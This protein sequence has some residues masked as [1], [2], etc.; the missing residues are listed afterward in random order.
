MKKIWH[1]F[2]EQWSHH[3]KRLIWSGLAVVVVLLG[4][5]RYAASRAPKTEYT[6]V[7]ATRGALVQSVSETG[8]LQPLS[9]LALNF[10]AAGRVAQT[11]VKVGDQ[12][13]KNQ[14][15]MV[16]DTSGLAI[17]LQQATANLNIAQA[18]L[19][20]LLAGASHEDIAV[21]QANY[22]AAQTA[23]ASAAAQLAQVKTASDAAVAQAQKNVED[24]ADNGFITTYEQAVAQAVVSLDNVAKTYGQAANNQQDSL[25]IT[26]GN[27]LAVVNTA[28]DAIDRII[29]DSSLT[30]Y[31]S[32]RNSAYLRQTQTQY[33][34]AKQVTA[35]AN[36]NLTA[37]AGTPTKEAVKAVYG[38]V[39]AAT[40][41]SLAALNSC[42]KVLE[43]SVAASGGMTQT[44][45]D[46][47]KTNISSQLTAVTAAA[48]I[49]QTAGQTWNDALLAYNTNTA[50]AN[51]ALSQA[52]AALAD[53]RAKTDNGLTNARL[54]RDRDV[55]AAQNQVDSTIKALAV[56]KAQLDKTTAGPRVQDVELQR[57]QVNQA[58][59]S[60]DLLKNQL[61]NNQIMA[62]V[63]G[64][65]TDVA[66]KN[67]EQTNVGQV[68]I[69]MM[70][71]SGFEIE[72]D[73]AETDIAKVKIND[74]A[75]IT[76]DAYGDS[77]KFD[78]QVVFIEPAATVIQGVIYYKVKIDFTAGDHPV[79]PDMTATATIVTARKD[80]V[81]L[82]PLRAVLD[83]TG[84]KITRVLINGQVVERPVRL[85]LTADGG[86]VEVLSGVSENEQVITYI[87]NN[88]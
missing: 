71:Q 29:N 73:V 81:V 1:F 48:T 11:P 34:L 26:L 68:A 39:T 19:D 85:G 36:D 69:K 60:I 9:E 75:A 65:I 72:I 27:K 18:Q 63:D 70:A 76:L 62:P 15:L 78:G 61:A 49:L 31:L 23:A 42:F 52:Q 21:A 25:I 17:Q 44:A 2:K 4:V 5:W 12:V 45:L 8:S 40:N 46:T 3:K 50:N 35:A 84:N 79:K 13:K 53:A 86:Q 16:L 59:A 28:L 82:I 7:A 24:L 20:K 57:A 47:F 33:T 6:T 67:G 14:V 74:P 83:T 77:V 10:S 43:N 80:N 30:N 22:Q 55:L 64:V 54:N 51:S 56:A 38:Q 87:K 37:L 41:D 32:V 88:N 58:Q 66:Y